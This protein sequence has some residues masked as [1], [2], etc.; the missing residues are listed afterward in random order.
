[1]SKKTE[2]NSICMC[3]QRSSKNKNIN[4]TFKKETLMSQTNFEH[5][6]EEEKSHLFGNYLV[7]YKK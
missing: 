1:M 6:K 7:I 4:D 5:F 2:S 3:A